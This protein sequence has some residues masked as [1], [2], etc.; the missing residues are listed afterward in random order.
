MDVALDPRWGRV[1][2]TYG[3]D[4]YL[5]AA[6]SVAYTRGLQGADLT[7]GVIATAKHFV[8]Y[9][10]ARGGVNLS[11]YEGGARRTRD[12]FA[13]PFEAAIQIAGLKS[14]MNSYSDVDGVPAGISKEVLVNLLRDT[15]GF[16]GFVSSDYMTLDHLVDRQRVAADAAEAGRLAIAAS[17]DVENPVP[18]GYGDV[19]AAEVERGAVDLDHVDAAVRRVLRAKF[20]S[21]DCLRTRIRPSASTCRLWRWKGEDFRRSWLGARSCWPRTRRSCRSSL[22]RCTSR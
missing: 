21:S 16:D 3:E 7:Q 9:A 13:Y 17:L 5:C 10:L 4:P 18:F 1:H 11:A 14:V 15:L 2:E 19:L 12:L 6:L 22:G 8:G 20:V